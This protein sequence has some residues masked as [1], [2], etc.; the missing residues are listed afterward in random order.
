MKFDEIVGKLATQDVVEI[1]GG[2]VMLKKK[3]KEGIGGESG[4]R[5]CH[6]ERCVYQ[7]P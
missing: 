2:A 4:C 3:V 5:N 6:V 7:T 1:N